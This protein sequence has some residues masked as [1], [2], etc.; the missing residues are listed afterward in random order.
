[1][2]VAAH[3]LRE[4]PTL[5]VPHVPGRR[6]HQPRNREG[7]HVLAHVDAHHALLRAVVRRRHS[8]GELRL[9]HAGGP[10]EDH[11][12]RRARAIRQP[13]ASAPHRA[14]DG[15]HRLR[16]PDDP[17]R[18]L[19]LDVQERR[20][21][22]LRE[23]PHRDAG[24]LR[25]D[26]RDV[27]G[28]HLGD[29][30]ALRGRELHHRARLVDHV[31]GLVREEAVGDVPRRE[32]HRRGERVF[33]V[34]HA[35]VLLVRALQ[36]LQDNERVLRGRLVDA[37]GLE[38]ALERSVLLD[39]RAVLLD[40]GSAHALQ[41]AARQRGLH[42]VAGVHAPVLARPACADQH[43]DLVHEQD[44]VSR[45]LHLLDDVL[46]ALLELAA[47]LGV[48]QEHAQLQTHHALVLEPV[49]HVAGDDEPRQP[50]GDGGFPD[51]GV[52]H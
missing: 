16:L 52:A 15:R 8:L 45:L 3:R 26:V 38:P 48:R 27:R 34:R 50:L 42:E 40:G 39:V 36:A 13:R 32:P 49:G 30:A 43:V 47:V 29:A 10:R 41:L 5:G 33:A 51:A 28:V 21:L 18:D 11:A 31:D 20:R 6:A 25:D 19:R 23:L 14:R 12:R 1:M 37:H 7:L 46:Q 22:I 17:P 2:R 4:L 9:A 35:V 24:P 44:D